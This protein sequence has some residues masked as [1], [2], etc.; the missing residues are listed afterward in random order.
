MK[1]IKIQTDYS[2]TTVY[3]DRFINDQTSNPAF[4]QDIDNIFS[5]KPLT[6][7]D[8]GCINGTLVHDF[9]QRGHNAVGLDQCNPKQGFWLHSYQKTLFSC[10][11][12]RNFSVLLDDKLMQCELIIGLGVAD[13][14][15][16]NL[17]SLFFENVQKHLKIQGL[18][19]GSISL[20]EPFPQNQVL[21]L[22][23]NTILRNLKG[24]RFMDY[25][26]QHIPYP[27]FTSFYYMLSRDY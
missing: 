10:D 9:I 23:Q 15:D 18:F 7:L 25:S 6:I 17:I 13:H 20:S 8:V 27:A 1:T 11:V 2:N 4:L 5:K 21:Q 22:W 26:L 19:I 3:K 14:I 12:S 16:P 24:L